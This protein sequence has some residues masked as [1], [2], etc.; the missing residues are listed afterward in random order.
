[1]F[2]IDFYLIKIEKGFSTLFLNI[3]LN[4]GF[5]VVILW[6]ILNKGLICQIAFRVIFKVIFNLFY[7]LHLVVVVNMQKLEAFVNL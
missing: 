2:K 7:V 4:V 6:N 5:E 3:T 1:M